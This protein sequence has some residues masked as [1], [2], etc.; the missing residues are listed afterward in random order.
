MKF[1]QATPFKKVIEQTSES[2][3]DLCRSTAFYGCAAFKERRSP[4]SSPPCPFLH[5]SR[6]QVC[7]QDPTVRLVPC[8]DQVLSRC[9]TGNHRYCE[10]YLTAAHRS[11]AV[12]ES[13]ARSPMKM[14]AHFYFTRNHMWLDYSAEHDCHVGVDAL[15]ARILGRVE[16]LSFITS[17]G[18]QC[19][20]VVLTTHGVTLHLVFP[21][22]MQITYTNP[23][24]RVDPE[25]MLVDPYGAGW[26]IEGTEVIGADIRC[27]LLSGDRATHWME[28]ELHRVTDLLRHCIPAIRGTSAPLAA[29]GGLPEEGAI[30]HL[31]R[32][33]IIQFFDELFSNVEAM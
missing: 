5:E 29:D 25:K 16:K 15:L 27:G 1:C 3:A 31:R 12:V 14:P 2:A 13:R 18:E 6:A 19:P 8:S 21:N 30:T 24:V 26:L 28:S 7:S 17:E 33:Q 32:S 11:E 9:V 23:Q 10:I 20:S 4:P 22:P